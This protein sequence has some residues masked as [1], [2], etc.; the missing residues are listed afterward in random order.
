MYVCTC[1][2]KKKTL[3]INVKLA[4]KTMSTVNQKRPIRYLARSS[5]SCLLRVSFI[6]SD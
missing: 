1:Y 4:A 3:I 5:F 2:Y 6:I